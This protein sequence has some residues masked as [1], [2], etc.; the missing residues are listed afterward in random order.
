MA[1]SPRIQ[2]SNLPFSKD[3]RSSG[4]VSSPLSTSM[5]SA[6]F[7]SSV[8][9]LNDRYRIIQVLGRGG[10]GITALAKD[11]QL[12]SHPYCVIKQLSPLS[13][14]PDALARARWRFQREAKTL[15]QLG[16]H[17]Q[18]PLLLNYF[19]RQGQFFLVQEFIPGKT[20]TQ[21][22]KGGMPWN[23]S[24][25]IQFLE[26]IL[27]VLVYV[28]SQGVIHR[29]IKPSNIIRCASDDR[30][31]LLDFGAVKS[32]LT[33]EENTVHSTVQFVGTNGFAPLE[34]QQLRPCFASDLYALG[35]TSLFLLTG[36]WPQDFP[37]DRSSLKV[38][39]EKLVQVSKPMFV[40]L[41]G[42]VH[43]DL[44]QRYRSAEDV[45]KAIRIMQTIH[46][47]NR[48]KTTEN[49]R[50]LEVSPKGKY[51]DLKDCLH[52]QAPK[53]RFSSLSRWQK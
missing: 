32:V 5:D 4:S 13:Q 9:V 26:A 24:Q 11:Y 18:I 45:L 7:R 10:F 2:S 23:E 28:H 51:D 38:Q 1:N 17:A 36:Q 25:V 20:L 50:F 43:P 33:A 39:W 46:H 47:K 21:L 53:R 19:E 41:S 48:Y 6:A 22:V 40:L 37:F 52:T 14:D 34:Q 44:S 27:P 8:Y 15:A 29:D 49:D 16:G 30:L 35:M 31:V 12:P 3:S 42:L